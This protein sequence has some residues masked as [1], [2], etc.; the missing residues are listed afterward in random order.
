MSQLNFIDLFT[1]EI[2][3]DT[4]FIATTTDGFENVTLRMAIL[5]LYCPIFT[6]TSRGFESSFHTLLP[7][8]LP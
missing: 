3:F 1:A 7:S 6:R 5:T 2:P 8:T 4:V